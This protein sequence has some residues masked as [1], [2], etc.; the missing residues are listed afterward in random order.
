MVKRVVLLALLLIA[1]VA[2]AQ[3]DLTGT[4][5]G[6]FIITV[7]GDTH[8]DTALMV[9]KHKGAELTGTAGPT[10]D[11][12]WPIVKAKV[13]GASVEFD[14]QSDEPL[15]HFALKLVEGHLKGEAKAEH[16]GH[17]LSAIVDL[18]RRDK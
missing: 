12:Q 11:H 15:I 14:V 2:G 7:D 9:L 17:K 13:D 4:W 16:D 18:Q 6:P 1:P 5:S 10:V 8:D 3:T